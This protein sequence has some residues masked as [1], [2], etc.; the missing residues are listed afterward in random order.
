MPILTQAPDPNPKTPRL[1][2]LPGACDSHIHLFGPAE[3][4]P[5]APDS[6]YTSRDA[7]PETFIA[8]Q[9]RLGLG[10]A[11]IVSPGG[12]GRNYQLLADTLEHHP[13]R[14]RGIALMP[15][16]TSASEFARLT[17]LGVRGLRMMSAKRGRHVPHL[18]RDIAARAAEHG[19]H[20]QFYPHDTD[21]LDYA[22]K[23]LALPNT[24][25]LDHFASVPAGGGVDQPAFRTVLEVLDSGRVW[26]KLSA[27]MRCTKQNYP[28][29]EVTPLAHALVRHAPER[30]VWGSD[31]PHVNLDGR[32]MPNDGDLVDLLEEW[33]PDST[34]RNRILVDNPCTLYG[35]P[36]AAKAAA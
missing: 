20:V 31:W 36:P 16:E 5:F 19:W 28:Y 8:L 24:I 27:P 14:F 6:P 4:Y 1:R 25:V 12:Y 13:D 7:L 2:T 3:K 21:I 23:L 32:E 15:D 9:D 34:T 17:R 35:F 29:R 30:L 11:V 33:V 26:L 10:H 22:D 18:A